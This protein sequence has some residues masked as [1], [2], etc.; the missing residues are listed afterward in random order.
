MK[1]ELTTEMHKEFR[2]SRATETKHTIWKV[3]QRS[4]T[5]EEILEALDELE[6]TTEDFNA[7]RKSYPAESKWKTEKL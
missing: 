6:M 5:K 3:M 2:V 4:K 1:E 7:H